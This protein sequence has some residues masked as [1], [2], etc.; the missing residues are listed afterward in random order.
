MQNAKEFFDK[1][2]AEIFEEKG[3]CII[4]SIYIKLVNKL[5]FNIHDI[6]DDFDVFVAFETMNNRG[7]RLSNLEIL[8]NRLIYLTTIYPQN[9]LDNNNKKILRDKI[10]E[11]WREVYHQLGRNKNK[12]LDDDEYLRNHW[13]LF[14]KYTRNKGDDYIQFLLNKQFTPKA[15]Y[16]EQVE[17]AYKSLEDYDDEDSYNQYLYE[18][19]EVLHPN[20]INDYVSSLR[21][22][23]QY[24]YISNNPNDATFLTEEEKR[25][26]NRLN[27]VGINYFR[28]LVVASLINNEITSEERISLYKTI[29]KFIFLCFRL[30]KYNANY[31]SVKAYTFAREIYFREIKISKVVDFFEEEFNKNIEGALNAFK[32]S[33]EHAFKSE[34]GYY[35]WY[36]R[37]YFLF[38]YEA[39]LSEGRHIRKLDDWKT[40]TKSDKDKI[41]IEHIF[42][43]KPTAYYW[44]NAFR[45]YQTEDEQHRLANSLGNLLALSQSINSSLQ[46][47]EFSLKKEP[48]NGR[49]GYADGS[50]SE[51]E[52][53]KY[54]DWTPKTILERGLHLLSFMEKR[55]GFE[56][57]SEDFKIEV[58]GLKF[59]Q[60]ER[61]D[62]PELE[63]V[64]YTDRDTHYSSNQGE[65]KVSEFLKGKDLY[66]V[67]Y[68]NTIYNA[69]LERIPSLYETATK[70]YIA[71]RCLETN[72]IIAEIH[73]QNSKRKI[74]IQTRAPKDESLQIGEILPESYLWSLNYRIF[75]SEDEEY[76][77]LIELLVQIFD[78]LKAESDDDA[79]ENQ[80]LKNKQMQRTNKMLTLLREYEA[81]GDITILTHARRYTRFVSANIREKVGLLGD[82]SWAGINDLIV[83]EINNRY[84]NCHLTLLHFV[85]NSI[86]VQ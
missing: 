73:I 29:E 74:L 45:L 15:V 78:M 3:S 18:N 62:I 81:K 40:F 50:Y 69:L 76:S 1:K 19:E 8:K 22:V 52:V 56:F 82:G 7:K 54:I 84:N 85:L 13:T 42:P 64:D 36:P 9:I 14:Y 35:S 23:A 6:D 28:T 25:W 66:M 79:D 55:W 61:A 41:S 65:I 32:S 83:Y 47:D 48:K 57:P 75:L 5:Q 46:N 59:L 67:K 58:L 86:N 34:D 4:E 31:D 80:E 20:E 43:Q 33:M 39:Y 53:S 38:E 77:T 26:L 60:E 21:E 16:G 44:R 24:W 63:E 51:M 72:K 37:W 49:R 10:N 70:H 68:Y 30:A 11:T 12:P 2:L 27:H 71:L 17:L